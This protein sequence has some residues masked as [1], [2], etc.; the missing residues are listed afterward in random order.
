MKFKILFEVTLILLGIT[1]LFF[2]AALLVNNRESL[3][4]PTIYGSIG[5]IFFVSGIGLIRNT[6]DGS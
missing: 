4:A 1:G 3:E 5:L 6:K 2:A